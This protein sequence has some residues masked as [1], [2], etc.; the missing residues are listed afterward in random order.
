MRVRV[1]LAILSVVYAVVGG[2][3]AAQ[4]AE[5][6][7]S[8]KDLFNAGTLVKTHGARQVCLQDVKGKLT[9]LGC[10]SLMVTKA[11]GSK[12]PMST[13]GPTGYTQ[14]DLAKAYNLPD[15]KTG[16]H[17]TIAIVGIGPY[18]SLESDLA[19]Y[20]STMGLPEC[21]KS[22]G[23]LKV[24]NYH[25]DAPPTA[26]KS[27]PLFM[28]VYEA[29]AEET[30]LDV[31]MASAACPTCK[32]VDVQIPMNI[33][34]L[35]L[36]TTGKLPGAI[37]TDFGT[38]V[39]TAVKMGA[40]SVSMSYGIPN[41]L[42]ASTLQSGAPAKALHHPG[43]A[44]LASSGDSGYTGDEQTFPAEDR[45]VTSAGGTSLKKADDGTFSEKAWGG[46][47]TPS[48]SD[49]AEW[50]GPG[51]G[52]V[53]TLDPAV[54]QPKSVSDNCKGHRTISDVSADADPKTGVAV[55]D[56]YF[57]DSGTKPGWLVFGGTSA[58]S[59]FLA[60]LFTRAGVPSNLDGP[61]TMYNAPAGSINDVTGGSNAQNGASDCDAEY[62]AKL[63]TGTSGWDGPTGVGSP[64][65]LGA[66]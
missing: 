9:H 66:F 57:P 28:S 29:Y 52:C 44:V 24:V 17:D 25:G 11:P 8:P 56:S 2:A 42:Q 37:A 34:K 53:T 38:A 33:P 40:K 54:G 6:K 61:N 58:S 48:G 21:S 45:W 30:A 16:S 43:V 47:F 41:G 22:N 51:S 19:K 23:C 31:Q 4:A 27:D 26:P 20:R 60:G 10:Q 65:G 59:P 36:A 18:P 5:H 49:T 62:T 55:Y 14:N 39:N 12:L 35:L 50:V 1:V 13:S 15:D 3:G 32:I 46:M 64:N 7:P 63:C